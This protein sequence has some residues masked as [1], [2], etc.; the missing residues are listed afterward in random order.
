MHFLTPLGGV[1]NRCL[2]CIVV[3]IFYYYLILCLV[4]LSIT[5]RVCQSAIITVCLLFISNFGF[6]HHVFWYSI[7][8]F[9]YKCSAFL[10]DLHFY[11]NKT[12]IFSL[13]LFMVLKFML[14]DINISHSTYTGYYLNVMYFPSCFPTS[15]Y[16]VYSVSFIDNIKL[17][18]LLQYILTIYN[19]K[20][21]TLFAFNVIMADILLFIYYMSMTY[22]FSYEFHV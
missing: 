4:V 20:V 7:F 11:C 3:Q 10:K 22:F 14:S 8:R 2:L 15:L 5:E 6:C 12:T 9:I 18:S 21:F 13:V 19:F 16:F 17:V 1:F